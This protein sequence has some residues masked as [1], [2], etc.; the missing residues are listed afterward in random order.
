[1]S[2][3]KRAYVGLMDRQGASSELSE[4]MP[5][6]ER[7]KLS[8]TLSSSGGG[9]SENGYGAESKSSSEHIATTNRARSDR[10]NKFRTLNLPDPKTVSNVESR[11]QS[12]SSDT[13][14]ILAV[15][16][17]AETFSKE[18]LPETNPS[19]VL[20][21]N[22][23]T[24]LALSYLKNFL[25][26]GAK[27]ALVSLTHLV[28]RLE[29]ANGQE[30]IKVL[31]VCGKVTVA[32]FKTGDERDE[33]RAY[34]IVDAVAVDALEKYKEIWEE[35]AYEFTKEPRGLEAINQ[36]MEQGLAG[37]WASVGSDEIV[38]VEFGPGAGW[39][40]Q[41]IISK[42]G[43]RLNISEYI[44]VDGSPQ[45]VELTRKKVETLLGQE[46]TSVE[47]GN[48][49]EKL[50]E[51]EARIDEKIA[52]NEKV[53]PHFFF[54]FSVM[55]YLNRLEFRKANAVIH[56]IMKKTQGLMSSH[57]K[58]P[59]HLAIDEVTFRELNGNDVYLGIDKN[60]RI[61]RHAYGRKGL[62]KEMAAAS[63]GDFDLIHR[64]VITVKDYDEKGATTF[65]SVIAECDSNPFSGIGGN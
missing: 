56:R 9:E 41:H 20:D 65:N 42:F 26:N 45:A 12:D 15:S 18:G 44:G 28:E 39:A 48:F 35:E 30:M 57:I 24:N 50:I 62:G 19:V 3:F 64:A 59:E 34:K 47:V 61:P 60:T 29:M 40:A 49:I 32:L 25:N 22:K 43:S 63:E 16:E 14:P 13:L 2:K 55:H 23:N 53:K 33:G 5:V 7:E 51:I 8:Y 37:T 1:M 4:S 54:H 38:M 52:K 58:N 21:V 10:G 17:K 6:Y 27:E 31:E 36:A 46:A 11:F